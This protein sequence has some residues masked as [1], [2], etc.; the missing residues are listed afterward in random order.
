MQ[1]FAA[2]SSFCSRLGLELRTP[3]C[4]S[5]DWHRKPT[6]PVWRAE[7]DELL[8][9]MWKE[10]GGGRASWSLALQVRLRGDPS[11]PPPGQTSPPERH[12][13][14]RPHYRHVR[15]SADIY[16]GP[17]RRPTVLSISCTLPPPPHTQYA[18]PQQ[19]HGTALPVALE[20]HPGPVCDS[21][22]REVPRQPRQGA[23]SPLR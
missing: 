6:Q 23:P 1:P 17:F 13:M 12:P 18:Q 8:Y 16:Q 7:A 5:H 15:G 2:L 14:P 20:V 3:V 4:V 10:C 9:I 21:K 22:R 11:T 19:G